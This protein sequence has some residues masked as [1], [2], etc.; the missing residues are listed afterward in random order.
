DLAVCHARLGQ[1]REE[2][3]RYDEALAIEPHPRHASIYLSN[4]AEALMNEGDLAG[5]QRGYS[6]ALAILPSE[7]LVMGVTTFWSLGVVLD[8]SGDHPRA[9]EQIALG[10]A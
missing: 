9:L 4:Q 6:A 3:A 1:R 5:A 2:I 8:R 10:R 7:W